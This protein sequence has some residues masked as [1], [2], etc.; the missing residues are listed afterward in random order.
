MMRKRE[1]EEVVEKTKK[2]KREKEEVVEK[3]KEK[4]I[5]IS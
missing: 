4:R 2:E 5:E 3:T 1:K